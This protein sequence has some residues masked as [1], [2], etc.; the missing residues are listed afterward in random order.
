M[1]TIRE[2]LYQHI[3][4]N[5]QRQIAMSFELSRDA[6][7]EYIELAKLENLTALTS[8]YQLNEIAIKVKEKLTRT[9]LN[10]IPK[11]KMEDDNMIQKS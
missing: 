1:T 4:G 7:R 10:F 9:E 3:K 2:V 8:D 11:F 6:I 5:S